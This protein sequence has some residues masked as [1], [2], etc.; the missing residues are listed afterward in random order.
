MATHFDRVYWWVFV[1]YLWQCSG[2]PFL[3]KLLWAGSVYLSVQ[4]LQPAVFL[5]ASLLFCLSRCH[6]K[7]TCMGWADRCLGAAV[8]SA[9]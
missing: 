4:L 9:A 5:C 1:P 3:H 2:C 8:A 7:A 6:A